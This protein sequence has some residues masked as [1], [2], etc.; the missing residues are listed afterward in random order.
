VHHLC[1]AEVQ[2]KLAHE[3]ISAL[4]RQEE[5][6]LSFIQ[7]VA[8]SSVSSDTIALLSQLTQ[9][10]NVT[11]FLRLSSSLFHPFVRPPQSC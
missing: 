9:P 8:C 11:D 1:E 7:T 3:I 6:K 5:L 2:K 10:V 4:E